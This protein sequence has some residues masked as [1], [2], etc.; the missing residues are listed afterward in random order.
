MGITR[1]N[2]YA[3]VALLASVLTLAYFL[4]WQRSVFFVKI[5]TALED[6]QPVPFGL[7]FSEVLLAV[8]IVAAGLGFPFILNTWMLPLQALVR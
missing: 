7:R 2:A 5:E 8:I 3:G 6:T 4:S 1:L